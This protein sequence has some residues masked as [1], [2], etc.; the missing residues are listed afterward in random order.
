RNGDIFHP[1]APAL[2]KYHQR[3][4]QSLDPAGILNPGRMYRGF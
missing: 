1:L 2:M 3:V 4:K